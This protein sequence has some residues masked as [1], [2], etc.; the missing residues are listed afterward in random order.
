MK[1]DKYAKIKEWIDSSLGQS[2]I[3]EKILNYPIQTKCKIEEGT[4]SL[5]M[6]LISIVI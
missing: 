5:K 2:N 4:L 3:G 1:I 6:V